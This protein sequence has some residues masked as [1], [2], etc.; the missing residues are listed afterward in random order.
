M[1]N[2]E[3]HGRESNGTLP[4]QSSINSLAMLY[5]TYKI[6]RYLKLAD[7]FIKELKA[8]YLMTRQEPLVSL[9]N[10]SFSRGLVYWLPSSQ[11]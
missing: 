5:I 11:K 7:K 2:S 6:G 9:S 3:N 10:G 1:E 4:E 8:S